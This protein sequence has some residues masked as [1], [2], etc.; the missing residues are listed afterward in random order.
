MLR[1]LAILIVLGAAFTL[2]VLAAPPGDVQFNGITVTS[3]SGTII[4]GTL[5]LGAADTNGNPLIGETLELHASGTIFPFLFNVTPI[6]YEID[7][8]GLA[9]G[10]VAMSISVVGDPST[11][12]SIRIVGC[13]GE[14]LP[15][16]SDGRINPGY[17]DL[18]AVLYNAETS[19]GPGIVVYVVDGTVG[20]SIGAYAGVLFQV[21]TPRENTI[22]AELGPTRLIALSSGEFQINIGPDAH[23]KVYEVIF[24]RPPG[25]ATALRY[26][27]D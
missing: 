2:P 14:I 10:P 11:E 16:A 8:P 12:S 25:P 5:L 19:T 26:F 21:D 18:L 9:S 3:C 1:K 22:I 17:G 6:P 27:G 4:K 13:S 15:Q 7:I 23:G 20:R 24:D